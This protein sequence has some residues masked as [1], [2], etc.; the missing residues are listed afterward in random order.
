MTLKKGDRDTVKDGGISHCWG[1]IQRGDGGGE[2]ASCLTVSECLKTVYLYEMTD[3]FFC[4]LWPSLGKC[5]WKLSTFEK[6]G[7]KSIQ[8]PLSKEEF[9]SNTGCQSVLPT[10]LPN[11]GY[12]SVCLLLTVECIQKRSLR[13]PPTGQQSAL[14]CSNALINLS[15]RVPSLELQSK[16]C[17]PFFGYSLLPNINCHNRPGQTALLK[18]SALPPHHTGWQPPPPCTPRL[19][20][21]WILS[22]TFAT[23][24]SPGSRSCSFHGCAGLYPWQHQQAP[25][26]TGAPWVWFNVTWNFHK[27]VSK[28]TLGRKTANAMCPGHEAK[29]DQ[30]RKRGGEER[31]RE[32]VPDCRKWGTNDSSF[33]KGTH[34]LH[35]SMFN[36]ASSKL[37]PPGHTTQRPPRD[38]FTIAQKDHRL[39]NDFGTRALDL[40]EKQDLLTTGE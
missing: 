26:S 13:S 32:G 16:V 25:I 10:Q 38:S 9:K 27:G 37:S 14:K 5:P 29:D 20:L 30:K 33:G 28:T 8:G 34:L 6:P 40:P 22:S 11:T 7:Y 19:I 12:G 3:A 24:L 21:K 15:F 39:Q 31:T 1:Q 18:Q 2:G 36:Q 23:T 35:L 4:C 17:F